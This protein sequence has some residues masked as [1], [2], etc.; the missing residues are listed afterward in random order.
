MQRVAP[1]ILTQPTVIHNLFPAFVGARHVV[2]GF[3]SA[4]GPPLTHPKGLEFLDDRRLKGGAAPSFR[5]WLCKGGSSLR[6]S[7][8]DCHG[9]P[10]I[11]LQPNHLQLSLDKQGKYATMVTVW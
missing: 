1:A 2:P 7:R 5:A 6:F 11:S 10:S 8:A 9:L 3:S 4:G